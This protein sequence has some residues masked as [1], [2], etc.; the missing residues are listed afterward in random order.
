MVSPSSLIWKESKLRPIEGNQLTNSCR[1]SAAETR[2]DSNSWLS[3]KKQQHSNLP[4]NLWSKPRCLPVPAAQPCVLWLVGQ[5]TSGELS[6]RTS[7]CSCHKDFA[8]LL[9]NLWDFLSLIQSNVYDYTR[10][11]FRCTY[12]QFIQK[13]NVPQ[14]VSS[15]YISRSGKRHKLEVTHKKELVR[16]SELQGPV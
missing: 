5:V 7:Y 15:F 13:K 14:K 11:E 6:A 2:Q 3:V 8:A 4:Q 12:A 1:W 9:S 16:A 10:Y